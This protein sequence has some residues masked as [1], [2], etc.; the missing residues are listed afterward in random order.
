MIQFS[1]TQTFH[2]NR[3]GCVLVLFLLY[4]SSVALWARSERA[5]DTPLMLRRN[6]ATLSHA[7]PEAASDV[8]VS[9]L[10]VSIASSVE[11]LCSS[12]TPE[13]MQGC[14]DARRF[15]TA[16]AES[17]RRLSPAEDEPW[18]VLEGDALKAHSDPLGA[19]QRGEVPAI[20]L[21]SFVPN[22]ELSRMLSRMAQMTMRI[23]SCRFPTTIDPNAARSLK[24][25]R[26]YRIS[27]ND[28]YCA[29]LNRH[30]GAGALAWPH[31]CTL[32][33]NVAHDCE[34]INFATE[35]PEC[36]ALRQNH[37]VFQRC[38][39]DYGNGQYSKARK[40][41]WRKILTADTVVK[42]AAREFGQKLYGNLQNG[43]KRKFM[44]SAHA[45]DALHE[46]MA[47]G[48]GTG[49]Y[50]SPKH[51]MLAG[52]AELAGPRRK[53]QQ[54]E[55]KPGEVHSP[56]T[57]RAMTQGWATP[58]HMD[59]KHSSAWAALRKELC[60]EVVRLTLGTS[61]AEASRFRALTR[62]RFAASAILTIHAPNRT[63]N[64]VDL[65]IFR[66]RWP[67]LLR[68]CSVRTVDAY[69]IG[70]RFHRDTMPSYVFSRPTQVRANPGD[71]F[72]FNSEFFHDTPRIRGRSSRTVF[73]SFA[74]FSAEMGGTVE[75]YA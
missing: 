11:R 53:T 26:S 47:R 74:G 43:A 1:R 61:P 34:N 2:E 68:N 62:H 24:L 13:S 3:S 10:Q 49:R 44:R 73:N 67:A 20:A 52:V 8:H 41:I 57:V 21:R 22:S 65:N 42:A 55:E 15:Q 29:E 48:C 71:L 6:S 69:G 45:V 54:A 64:P 38:L 58:L 60:G 51:A 35:P 16:L 66:T 40:K 12:N 32:L 36:K 39:Y 50:C 31:W 25:A 14:N 75:V 30:A 59:S 18:D 37:P 46:L 17:G 9:R 56:G 4:C 5:L 28:S 19:L 27:S 7:S 72:L 70:A 33:V 23:F 63:E